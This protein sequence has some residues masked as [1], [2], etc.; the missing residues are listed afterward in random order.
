M[1]PT[2][3]QF[4]AYQ[5]LY[6]YFNEKLFDGK[7]PNALLNFSRKRKQVG[8]FFSPERWINKDSKK[9]HEISLNPDCSR[10]DTKV[11]ISIL[12]HEMVHLWQ[13][14]FGEPSRSGY[15]NAEWADKMEEIGLMPS[16]TGEEGGKRTGQQMTHYV[17]QSGA[18]DNAYKKI[19]AKM[20]L[21]FAQCDEPVTKP[22]SKARTKY[23]C[24]NCEANVWG[25]A[26]LSIE[27][28]SCGHS[29]TETN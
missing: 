29:F 17:I 26:G 5:G 24:E 23:T 4:E 21:P 7:L 12:V 1:I 27:C 8:G 25:K 19:T 14:E 2:K 11:V 10:K 18:F 9:V 6:Q 22:K 28:L 13:Q 20:L 3:E 15:H 16:N